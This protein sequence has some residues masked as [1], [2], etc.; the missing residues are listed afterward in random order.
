MRFLPQTQVLKDLFDDRTLVDEAKAAAVEYARTRSPT[1]STMTTRPP[2]RRA[3][4]SAGGPGAAARPRPPWIQTAGGG[5]FVPRQSRTHRN[6]TPATHAK[7]ATKMKSLNRIELIGHVGADPEIR[8][9][10]GDMRVASLTLATNRKLVN[11]HSAIERL[12]CI[13]RRHQIACEL[14][15]QR[16]PR[17]CPAPQAFLLAYPS[18]PDPRQPCYGQ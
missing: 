4:R 2:V 5:S 15:N 11:R 1:I 8:T 3:V 13:A 12:F 6:D 7:G 16:T 17:F 10:K 18:A 9:T 14:K